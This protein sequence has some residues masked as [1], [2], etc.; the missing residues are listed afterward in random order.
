MYLPDLF[1]SLPTTRAERWR[2]VADLADG[3][4][5]TLTPEDGFPEDAIRTAEARLGFALPAALREASLLF[6]WKI[7]LASV[8]DTIWPP[9]WLEMREGLLVFMAMSGVEWARTS[10]AE[11]PLRAP[12]R[13]AKGIGRRKKS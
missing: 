12:G 5:G 10:T 13:P 3:W 9:H 6:G 4:F 11:A 2:R 7:E 1:A 8:L